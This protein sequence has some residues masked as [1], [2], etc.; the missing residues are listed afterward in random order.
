MA[1]LG[2]ADAG[3][4]IGA[5]S[6]TSDKESTNLPLPATSSSATENIPEENPSSAA[7]KAKPNHKK[8]KPPQPYDGTTGEVVILHE[9]IVKGDF[10]EKR[11]WLL[12]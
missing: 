8:L 6:N 10:W 9:D 1:N 11:P 2:L 7:V 3:G 5:A 12:R 4:S